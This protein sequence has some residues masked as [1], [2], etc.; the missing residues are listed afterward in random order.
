MPVRGSIEELP[1]ADFLQMLAMN[2]KSGVLE[3]QGEK[4]IKIYFKDG[5]LVFVEGAGLRKFED[6]LKS[7]GVSIKE[8]KEKGFDLLKKILEEK[9]LPVYELGKILE[10][11]LREQMVE[12]LALKRG[13][14]VFYETEIDNC[15]SKDLG[16]DTVA[17]LMDSQRQ[18]DEWEYLKDKIKSF[19]AIPVLA[20]ESETSQPIDFGGLEWKV[21]AWIDGSRSIK[22]IM[23]IF[24]ENY[25][26]ILKAIASLI[27]KNVVKLKMPQKVVERTIT[28]EDALLSAK[29]HAS[30]GNFSQAEKILV[31]VLTE[32]PNNMLARLLLGDVYYAQGEYEKSSKEYMEVLRRDP[33]NIQAYINL[34]YS[35]IGK[36][37]IWL[38]GGVIERILK[39]NPN[40]S[41]IKKLKKILEDL[42]NELKRK[43]LLFKR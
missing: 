28:H 29:R 11:F 2:A 36:G 31:M 33:Q 34:V 30:E 10:S 25:Y 6:I 38:A 15:I 14:F 1:L 12:I 23:N 24:P 19:D 37:D 7:A 3:I 35:L 18:L 13:N 43:K 32:N 21:L 22:E 26:E 39:L 41:E 20:V 9:I 42:Q 27:D 5:K 8:Y 4:N 40:I 16:L 17:L